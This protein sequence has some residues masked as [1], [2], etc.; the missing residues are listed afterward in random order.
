MRLRPLSKNAV[1]GFRP[2]FQPRCRPRRELMTLA[3]ETSCDDTS[4]AIVEKGSKHHETL[5]KLHFHKK[6]TSDN[7]EYK[8]VHPI[9]SLVSHQEHLANLVSE[10]I[11]HLPDC[12]VGRMP[13]S[14]RLRKNVCDAIDISTKRLP[15][16][17]SVTRGPGMRS[18]LFAGLDLAKGLTVAWQ[19]HALTPR[20]VS[21]LAQTATSPLKPEFPF[22]S[23][24]ASGGHTLLIQSESLTN[25]Y[26][27][28]TTNDIAVGECL[29]KIAR[30]VLPTDVLQNTRHTM[31]GALLEKFAFDQN[32]HD[33]NNTAAFGNDFSVPSPFQPGN[34]DDVTA[35]SAEQFLRQSSR[36][37][38]F[39]KVPANHEEASRQNITK[40]GWSFNQPLTKSNGGTKIRSIE[41]SFSGLLTAVERVIRYETDASTMKLT[42]VERNIDKFNLE[43]RQDIARE[44]MRAAFEHVTNRVVLCLQAISKSSVNL[45]GVV[46]AGGVA[47]NHFMRHMMRL[48]STLCSRGYSDIQLYFPPPAY[49]TD[50]AAMIAWAGLE[51]F[52]AGHTDSLS[53]RAVRKWPLDELMT[54]V[55]DG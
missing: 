45:P 11:S 49:C 1:I 50:N 41:L 10:A 3:I 31:Y 2:L 9:R 24:L 13:E 7:S 38:N 36:Q 33:T 51:M 40:W 53:I 46:I 23:V 29:D 37:Y 5:A 52:E 42:K 34:I 35:C 12:E 18:N 55:E 39:Y 27:L 44:A 47:A 48:A 25:Q 22:L 28:G 16:F 32:G 30:L 6:V 17:V 21:A 8:G 43:E 54:P 19:A 4:V 15:D 26:V 14:G 20:L